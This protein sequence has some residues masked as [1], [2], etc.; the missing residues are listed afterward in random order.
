M[1]NSLDKNT[2]QQ[3]EGVVEETL[4]SLNFKVKLNDGREIL[5]YLGGKLR[6]YRIKILAGDKVI[7]ELSPDGRRGRIIRRL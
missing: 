5:A 7:I 2:P 1:S 4:P 6:L 3:L